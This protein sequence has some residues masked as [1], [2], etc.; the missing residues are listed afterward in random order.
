VGRDFLPR[1]TGIVT[2]RPLILQLYN[3][4]FL[5]GGGEDEGGREGGREGI[6][7]GKEWGEFLHR[8]GERFYDF[9]EIRD[10]IKRETDRLTGKN[11]GISAKSINLKIYS[12][13]VLNLTLVDLPGITKV[14]V[15]DQP[16][17]IESQIRAMCLAY[18]G[19]PN[20]IILAVTAANTGRRGGR[21]RD[22]LG[23]GGKGW[24]EWGRGIANGEDEGGRGERPGSVTGLLTRLSLPP[25]QTSPIPTP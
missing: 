15:G 25:L 22:C 9:M 17:D 18:I 3:T 12:P 7:E 11:K 23:G 21:P 19:N 24:T 2:R 16:A 20:S 6:P 4:A 1:G 8:A 5:R 10:E 13:H 14:S